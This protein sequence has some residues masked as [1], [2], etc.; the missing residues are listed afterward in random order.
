M[1]LINQGT[2]ISA[3]PFP[4]YSTYA[5]PEEISHGVGDIIVLYKQICS[6]Y[7]SQGIDTV[8]D[9]ESRL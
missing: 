5:N 8:R 1:H 7:V 6:V 2:K 9:L 4:S 3:T